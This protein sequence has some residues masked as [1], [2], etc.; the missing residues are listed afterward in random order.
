MRYVVDSKHVVVGG[1]KRNMWWLLTVSYIKQ[2]NE[3]H[4]KAET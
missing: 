3:T 4:P 1:K 2:F